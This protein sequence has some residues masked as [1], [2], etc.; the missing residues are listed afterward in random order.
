MLAL[1]SRA[2]RGRIEPLWL[3][4]AL[5]FIRA[6]LAS[7][8]SNDAV[9]KAA[10]ISPSRLVHAFRAAT[11]RTLRAYVNEARVAAA[12]QALRTTSRPV[13]DI[14]LRTLTWL[15]AV[16]WPLAGVLCLATLPDDR[17]RWLPWTLLESGAWSLFTPAVVRVV[18]RFPLSAR[19][20]RRVLLVHAAGMIAS[21]ALS[22]ALR[23]ARTQ[24]P[25]RNASD[26]KMRHFLQ[27]APRQGGRIVVRHGERI[28]FLKP[29]EI[30]VVEAVGNYVR[31]HRGG[32][33]L[34]LRQTLAATEERLAPHGFVRIQRSVLVNVE[35]VAE[36]RREARE[37]YIV[38]LVTGTRYRLSPH[39]RAH[40][41]NALGKF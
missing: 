36:L 40:L 28:L 27:G 41:E 21:G 17:L 31:L 32:D 15:F 1:G 3:P 7:P 18:E 16:A 29:A 20:L 5:E 38:V 10:G 26:E 24:L 39:Y 19:P 22:E 8:L 2:S 6:N 30:D 12:A 13:A 4:R 23:R 14:A 25:R 35:R 33:R 9:A 11:G 37:S 34:L